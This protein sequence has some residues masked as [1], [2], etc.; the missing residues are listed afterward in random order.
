MKGVGTCKVH[1]SIK[2]EEYHLVETEVPIQKE[3]NSLIVS[4]HVF[5]QDQ[6]R[7]LLALLQK[8]DLHPRVH[9][10]RINTSRVAVMN[11]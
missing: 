5:T 8:M 1:G 7:S 11:Q 9:A 4:S 2:E 10:I 6:Y 3:E